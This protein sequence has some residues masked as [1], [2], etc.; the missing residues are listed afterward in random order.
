M[1]DLGARLPILC[2]GGTNNPICSRSKRGTLVATDAS[3]CYIIVSRTRLHANNIFWTATTSLQASNIPAA[4]CHCFRIMA[5]AVEHALRQ[6]QTFL[7]SPFPK[8]RRCSAHSQPRFASLSLQDAKPDT[9]KVS[10]SREKLLDMANVM[11]AQ[12]T[13]RP[14]V[15][16]STGCTCSSFPFRHA[17]RARMCVRPQLLPAPPL[18]GAR[19]RCPGRWHE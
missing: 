11:A 1:N 19:W 12:L 3:I 2:K 13:L 9:L 5:E 15:G 7:C 18:H 14:Q 17:E 16:D 6:M 10:S 8:Q 4:R